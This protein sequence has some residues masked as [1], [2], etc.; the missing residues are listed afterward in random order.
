MQKGILL[1]TYGSIYNLDDVERYYKHILKGRQL[2]KELLEELKDKYIKIGGKSPLN[3]ISLSIARKL[4]SELDRKYPN[5]YK[6]YLGFKHINPY[7]EE[8]VKKME[9]DNIN[10][11]IAIILSPY[12]SNYNI[13]DYFDRIKSNKIKFKYVYGYHL[14][15]YLIDGFKNNIMKVIL[16][17][18]VKIDDKVLFLFSFHSLPYK[19][20]EQNDV[21]V[22]QIKEIVDR[23]VKEIGIIN[24]AIGYQSIPSYAKEKWLTPDIL[25]IVENLN[26]SIHTLISCPIGFINDHL[27]VLY[28]I[29]IVLKEN[30]LKKGIKFYRIEL[31]NDNDIFIKCI[32]SLI[33]E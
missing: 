31:L 29:D 13:K 26:N 22:V 3:E 19:I 17:N 32:I 14:N 10:E 28:D 8:V 25:E 5:L 23:L 1:L 11:A 21:Y 2:T 24:Y 12:Y 33:E 15:K 4:Q 20:L 16:K 27:E 30:V 18:D 9:D 6:V 7:I